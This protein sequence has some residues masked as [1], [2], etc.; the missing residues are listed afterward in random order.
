[1]KLFFSSTKP[2]IRN[3]ILEGPEAAKD[4]SRRR[5]ERGCMRERG[6]VRERV[7]S[8]ER[9]RGDVR[10]RVSER[11]RVDVRERVR[12]D[13]RERVHLGVGRRRWRWFHTK[14]KG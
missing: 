2:L 11:V 10:E 5:G 13:V 1:M 12:G 9:E 3:N 4:G 6:D 7:R 8:G 14:K